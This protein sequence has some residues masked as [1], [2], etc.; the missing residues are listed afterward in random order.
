MNST[1]TITSKGQTTIPAAIRNQLGV[2]KSG[3][4]LNIEFNAQLGKLT[5]TKPLD[6]NDLSRRA[7]RHI[8]PGTK[9][10]LLVDEYYQANRGGT[11]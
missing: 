2:A 3:G 1:I 6:V 5:I 4:V 11:A 8:K 9:P 7:S 10:L